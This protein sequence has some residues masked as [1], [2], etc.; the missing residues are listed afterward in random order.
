MG[1]K[2]KVAL[3]GTFVGLVAMTAAAFGQTGTGSSGG[4]ST[5]TSAPRDRRAARADRQAAT[6]CP[7]TV[8]RR[9]SRV[10]HRET[11]LKTPAGF[12]TV[13]VDQGEITSIDHARKQLTIRRLDGQTVSATATD[14]TKVCRDGKPSSFDA[15][16]VGDRAR[17]GQVRSERFT[18][19]RRIVAL[20]PD[21]AASQPPA[22]PADF[23]GDGLDD[24]A[25]GFF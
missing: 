1:T 2:T 9:A 17:L 11:M 18:G 5:A 13:I 7:T 4:A 23:S 15:L 19:L 14:E 22:S 24:P 12:A 3:A 20:S 21:A 25:G 6:R 10:V 16:K 8:P